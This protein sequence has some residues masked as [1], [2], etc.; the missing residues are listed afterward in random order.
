METG[1]DGDNRELKIKE[2]LLEIWEKL[3]PLEST[4]GRSDSKIREMDSYVSRD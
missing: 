4:T 2:I 3:H 1:F